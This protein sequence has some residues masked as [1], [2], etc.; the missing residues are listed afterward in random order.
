MSIVYTLRKKMKDLVIAE[1]WNE[2]VDRVNTDFKGNQSFVG[3]KAKGKL[4]LH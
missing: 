3:R 4:F 2:V 1:V